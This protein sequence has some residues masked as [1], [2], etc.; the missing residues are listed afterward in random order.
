[1]T[2][3]LITAL[4]VAV[5]CGCAS[6]SPSSRETIP[7]VSGD[8]Q[9]RGG[10]KYVD[11]AIGN[12]RPIANGKCAYTHYT[13]WL[14]DGTRIDTS[15]DGEPVAFIQGTGKVMRGWEIGF[16]GMRAGMKRRLMV[17]YQLAYGAAGNPPRVPTRADLV[18]DVEL[19][20]VSDAVNGQCRAWRDVS[21]SG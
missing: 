19:M 11:V 20:A 10:I 2:R 16:D 7:A 12:G 15:R 3:F 5:L 6:A 4:C 17:P 8:T 1:M 9:A 18:F 13:A 14:T 21:R